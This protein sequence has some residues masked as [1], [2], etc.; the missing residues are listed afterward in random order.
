MRTHAHTHTD[1]Y[2]DVDA[3]VEH[4]DLQQSE[5]GGLLSQLKGGLTK[6]TQQTTPT[7]II[8]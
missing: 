7:V 3:G 8:N 2:S 6:S 4:H 5:G 1:L